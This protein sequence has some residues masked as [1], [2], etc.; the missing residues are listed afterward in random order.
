MSEDGRTPSP[1]RSRRTVRPARE[2]VRDR[3]LV[4]AREVFRELGYH[5]ASLETIA[6]RAGFSKGAVY[7]NFAGKDDLFL[8]L[9]EAE[10]VRFRGE[11]ER[12]LTALPPAGDQGLGDLVRVAETLI[13]VARDGRGQLA[14]A[15]FRAHA[16][17]DRD[18]AQLTA[19]V[20]ST[21]VEATAVQLEEALATRGLRLTIA[22]RDAAV[23]LLSLTNGLA[24]E[25]VGQQADVVSASGLATVLASLVRPQASA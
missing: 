4:A 22:P 23:V 6:T 10:I 12:A 9:L 21:L 2:D 13:A 19:H 16:A 25:Q 5:A 7:S 20:R 11:V 18:L 1:R 3:V 17:G 24:L 8:S 14:F 15:E